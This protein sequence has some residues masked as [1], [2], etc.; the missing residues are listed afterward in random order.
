MRTTA[1]LVTALL[2]TT[3]L[4]AVPTGAH[5]GIRTFTPPQPTTYLT[6]AT[7]TS[8]PKAWH[9]E[10]RTKRPGQVRHYEIWIDTAGPHGRKGADFLVSLNSGELHVFR[11]RGK[12]LA[13]GYAITCGAK[14]STL[15]SGPGLRFTLPQRCLT[16]FESDQM[17]VERLRARFAVVGIEPDGSSLGHCET[18]WSP[19]SG[20]ADFHRWVAN[21]AEHPDFLDH[22]AH[23]EDP[24]VKPFSSTC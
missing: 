1:R 14:T 15:A 4:T 13:K 18:S 19:A 5:A 12:K 24:Q 2:A 9:L 3:L 20:K 21:T 23:E 22:D 17:S 10:V 6:S 8:T 7:I 16:Y 11:L